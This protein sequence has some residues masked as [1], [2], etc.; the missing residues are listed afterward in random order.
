MFVPFGR[1]FYGFYRPQT[2]YRIVYSVHLI[3]GYSFCLL[4]IITLPSTS[5]VAL[6]RRFAGTFTTR[7]GRYS[8]NNHIDQ[9]DLRRNSTM[10]APLAGSDNVDA[11][12]SWLSTPALQ[13]KPAQLTAAQSKKLKLL[14]K[15]PLEAMASSPMGSGVVAKSAPNGGGGGNATMKGARK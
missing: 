3:L 6:R 8:S 7:R 1:L 11:F 2:W 14:T 5:T 12:L 13:N 4:L 9:A 10:P 15:S